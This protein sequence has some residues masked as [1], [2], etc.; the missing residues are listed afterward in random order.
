MSIA[1]VD[2]DVRER[3]TNM[4]RGDQTYYEWAIE[5]IDTHDDIQD[6]WHAETYAEAIRMAGWDLDEGIVKRDV[7]LVYNLGNTID[8]SVIE[9]SWAYVEDGRLPET[10]EN[11]RSVPK[12]YL[13]EVNTL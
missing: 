2:S 9:R 8:E 4:A 13:A 6:V 3:E 11:G 1:H 12:R 5:N 7:C 10:F